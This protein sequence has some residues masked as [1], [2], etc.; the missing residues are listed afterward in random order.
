[1][2]GKLFFAD[3]LQD[4]RVTYA[5]LAHDVDA[6]TAIPRMYQSSCFYDLFK[7]LLAAIRCDASL[8]L[9]D[10]DL[11][12][13]EVAQLTQSHST[14]LDKEAIPVRHEHRNRHVTGSI[15]ESRCKIGIF[16]SGTTG[17]PKLIEHTV[18]TLTRSVRNGKRHTADV[19]GFAYNPT[20]FA[21]LQVLLQAVSNENSI[22]R[23]F[24]LTPGQIHSTI[25]NSHIS[26]I[27]STPTFFRM[28]CNG[29]AKHS[30]VQHVTTGGEIIGKDLL[31]KIKYTF[32][33]AKILNVYASTEAGSLFVSDGDLFVVKDRYAGMVKVIDRELAL[34]HSLLAASLQLSESEEFFHTGDVVDIVSNSPLSFRFV[35]RKSEIINVGGYKVTPHEIEA[36]LL[37]L[38]EIVDARVYGMKNSVTGNLVC[39]DV[40]LAI[41]K[42][43]T[44]RQIRQKLEGVLQPYKI[45]RVINLV[46]KIGSTTT[47]KLKR[48]L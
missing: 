5:Q 46:S 26:H 20:H 19:W 15:R 42:S 29:D 33:S 36:H 24:G 47:G 3:P 17:T 30:G 23:L 13:Q 32:P 12:S 7:M 41:E 28:L 4:I 10:E 45:P 21:G 1:M 16:T 43:I 22:V 8:A 34:H 25:E 11:S 44:P 40:V 31:S 9:L 35:S 37:E 2:A 48:A 38:D 39:C 27:S 6:F 18:D 14:E